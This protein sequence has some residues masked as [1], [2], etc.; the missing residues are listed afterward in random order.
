[1]KE[2]EKETR[3]STH[4]SSDESLHRAKLRIESN[5]EEHKEEETGPQRGPRKLQHRRGIREE[6][7]TGAG[8]RDFGHR[9]LLLV[10]HEAD[11][12]EDD[13][14]CEHTRRRVHRADDQ[15]VLV[16]VV[17]EFVVTSKRD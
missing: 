15:R 10:G 4:H 1:M 11:D 8:S 13:E 12:G 17:R 6:G 2:R 16:H 9:L 3:K 5:E 7:Q 14:A